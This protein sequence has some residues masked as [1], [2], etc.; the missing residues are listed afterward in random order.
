MLFKVKVIAGAKNNS[1]EHLE[2]GS[3][4]LRIAQ[5]AVD[6]KANKEIINYLSEAYKVPK[7]N[8]NIIKGEKSSHKTIEI[9]EKEL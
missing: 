5:K 8:V 6:G 9:T 7:K 4:K 3:I 2:D 1:I